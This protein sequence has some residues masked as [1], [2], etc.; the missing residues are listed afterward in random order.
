MR[1]RGV[2]CERLGAM[3]GLTFVAL[4][5]VGGRGESD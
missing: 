4:L 2:K 3:A 1:R 5:L